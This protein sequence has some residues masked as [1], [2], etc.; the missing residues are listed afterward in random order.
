LRLSRI[1][2]GGGNRK[3]NEERLRDEEALDHR[4]HGRAVRAVTAADF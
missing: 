4:E 2:K 1:W 3:R